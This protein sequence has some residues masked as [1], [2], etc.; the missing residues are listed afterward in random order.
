[1]THEM[2]NYSILY[3]KTDTREALINIL[4]NVG[5][6]ENDGYKKRFQG[7]ELFERGTLYKTIDEEQILMEGWHA[8]LTLFGEIPP[9]LEA[10]CIYPVAPKFIFGG[11]MPEVL[12]ENQSSPTDISS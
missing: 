10:I 11:W 4:T 3:L 6:W 12:D 2:Q 7:D 8:D 9:E 1:M 5:M